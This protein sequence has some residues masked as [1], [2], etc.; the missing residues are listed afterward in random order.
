M[1]QKLKRGLETILSRHEILTTHDSR[2]TDI[3]I[4][5]EIIANESL[6]G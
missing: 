5:D 2:E 6:E 4:L 1:T 3:F